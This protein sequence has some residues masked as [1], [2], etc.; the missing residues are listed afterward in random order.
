MLVLAVTVGQ[1]VVQK[2]LAA[3]ELEGGKLFRPLAACHK[4]DQVLSPGVKQSLALL[5]GAE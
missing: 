3:V 4:N 2:S 1:E 5:K